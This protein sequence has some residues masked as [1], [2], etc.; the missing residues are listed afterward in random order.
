CSAGFRPDL[1]PVWV[2]CDRCSRS[3]LPV[4][5]RLGPEATDIRSCREMR[6][7]AIT[8]SQAASLDQLVGANQKWFWNCEPVCLRG[9]ELDHKFELG[10]LL[11]RNV[12]NLGASEKLGHYW[13]H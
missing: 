6:R 12:G 11:D 3:C 7:C 1:R 9:L 10:R 4:H 5:V 8:G 2:I 13:G